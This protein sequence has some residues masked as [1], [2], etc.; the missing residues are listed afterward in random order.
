MLCKSAV[1]ILLNF[2]YFQNG[3]SFIVF[4][5]IHSNFETLTSL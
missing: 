2:D 1:A 3:G 5:N 4:V